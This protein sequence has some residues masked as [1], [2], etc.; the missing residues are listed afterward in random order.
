MYSEKNISS[1]K[2]FIPLFVVIVTCSQNLFCQGNAQKENFFA[3]RFISSA[4]INYSLQEE[5]IPA[6]AGVNFSPQLFLTTAYSDFSFSVATDL[7][8]NYRLNNDENDFS[9]KLFFQFP[10]MLQFNMG[11]GASKDF[12]SAL[13]FFIGAGWNLQYAESRAVNGFA[14]EAGI[15]FWLLGKS[16]SLG[17]IDCPGNKKIFSSGKIISLQLNLG[18]YLNDVKANNKVS[19]FM[20]PYRK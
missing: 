18:K 7:T 17:V 13:G 8:V 3:K 12:H 10:A 5:N 11:H 19:N 20:K 4:G 1:G 9:K 6:T 16:F 14:V 15:R 2:I